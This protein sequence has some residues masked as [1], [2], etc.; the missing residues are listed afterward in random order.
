MRAASAASCA[1]GSCASAAS[2]SQ[3]FWP[4]KPSAHQPSPIEKCG[5]PLIEAFMPPV[6]PAS[7]GWR[8]GVGPPARVVQPHV[9]AL[10]EEMCDVQ[11]VVVHEG[12]PAAEHRI[13]RAPV[14]LLQVV[15]AG[16]VGRRRLAGKHDLHRAA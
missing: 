13:D 7:G 14:D 16:L 1:W 8:G 10:H 11:I 5:T 2:I 9:A 12:D 15:L 4:V 6:P 3:P